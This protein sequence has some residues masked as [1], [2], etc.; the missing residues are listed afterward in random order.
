MRSKG[1]YLKQLKP[2]LPG[3]RAA[4]ATPFSNALSPSPANRYV[5][6]RFS[7]GEADNAFIVEFAGNLQVVMERFDG[8][9]VIPR[10]KIDVGQVVVGVGHAPLIANAL[11]DIKLF[12]HIVERFGEVADLV[13]NAGHAIE[14]I[15]QAITR[16]AATRRCLAL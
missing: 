5:S 2:R 9:I 14:H 4:R 11:R 8:P 7:T 16:S 1:V 10:F 13:I 6:A 12:V 15:G 3:S